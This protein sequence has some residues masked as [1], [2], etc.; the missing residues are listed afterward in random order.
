RSVKYGLDD[1]VLVSSHNEQCERELHIE[2][3]EDLFKR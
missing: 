1:E 2:L 3:F